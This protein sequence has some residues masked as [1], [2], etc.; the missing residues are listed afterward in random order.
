M[1]TVDLFDNALRIY[2]EQSFADDI[3]E[4]FNGLYCI[5]YALSITEEYL[6]YNIDMIT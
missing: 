5:G 2:L 1:N 6:L 4:V 3:W